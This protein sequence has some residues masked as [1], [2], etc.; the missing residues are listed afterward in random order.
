MLNLNSSF[1]VFDNEDLGI[2][3][4]GV[5]QLAKYLNNSLVIKSRQKPIYI[6]LDW[7]VTEKEKNQFNDIGDNIK[8]YQFNSSGCNPDLDDSFNGIER[9]LHTETIK[10]ISTA[11]NFSYQTDV[12]NSKILSIRKRI[13]DLNKNNMKTILKT[14]ITVKD[15]CEG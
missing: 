9:Y 5:L 4:G 1:I 15:I 2:D 11:Y 14:N 12:N 13:F 8:M 10:K 3:S 6:I 7:N